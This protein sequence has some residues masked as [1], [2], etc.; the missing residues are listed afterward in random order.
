MTV[1]AEAPAGIDSGPPDPPSRRVRIPNW[2]RHPLWWMPDIPAEQRR[3]FA[4]I[5][6]DFTRVES[7]TDGRHD[8]NGWSGH[9]GD[10][11]MCC[12]RIPITEQRPELED[13]RAELG[14]LHATRVH[15]PEFLH[16]TVQ[17]LGYVTDTPRQREEFTTSR[18]DEFLGYVEGP[19]G[20]F[21]PFPITL[22]GANSFNDAPFLEVHDNGWLSRIHFRMRDFVI[23]PPDKHFPYLPFTTVAHYMSGESAEMARQIVETYRTT[24]FAQF[25]V[26]AIDVVRLSTSEPYPQAEVVRTIEL[27]RHRIEAPIRPTLPDPA[28][29]RFEER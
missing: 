16:I 19:I 14:T 22:G 9:G 23:V 10:F 2:I 15:P 20:D 4:R 17:E 28:E 21:A 18:L 25:N 24:T 26:S 11:V 27:G 7:L 3:S 13:F 1:G 8:V 29:H 12:V 6:D 5:W